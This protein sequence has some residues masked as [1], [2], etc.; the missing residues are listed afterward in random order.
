M[1]SKIYAS[2]PKFVS[3]STVINIIISH[4]F[5]HLFSSVPYEMLEE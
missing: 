5:L 1:V 3:P 4:L 2:V